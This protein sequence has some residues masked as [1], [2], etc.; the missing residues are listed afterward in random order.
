MLAIIQVDAATGKEDTFGDIADRTVKCAL[1]LVGQ[2]VKSGDVVAI[3][4]H[5][6]IDAGIPVL[7]CLCIGAIFNPWW[8]HGLN[9][10]IFCWWALFSHYHLHLAESGESVYFFKQI[11][12]SISCSS[13]L[14]NSYLLMRNTR[15]WLLTLLRR[16][17]PISRLLYL[18]AAPN[19]NHF[20]T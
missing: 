20:I 1:W 10:G 8:D 2:G 17:R 6:H 16:S 12:P 7:A 5:N 13:Q 4:T 3:C 15:H 19:T 14:Q 9:K 11:P 18:V